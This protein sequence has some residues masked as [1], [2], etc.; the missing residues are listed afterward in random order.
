MGD[1][2]ADFKD[3]T[4]ASRISVEMKQNGSSSDDRMIDALRCISNEYADEGDPE[5][6]GLGM[7]MVSDCQHR[8]ERDH[9]RRQCKIDI[10]P[11]HHLVLHFI[12]IEID[13]TIY[14]NVFCARC[15]HAN[16][17]RGR[18][19]TLKL[20]VPTVHDA[21]AKL[22]IDMEMH[23]KV[24]L[25]QVK[26]ACSGNGF[27]VP[28]ARSLTRGRS[29]MGMMCL[30]PSTGIPRETDALVK[31]AITES[32]K[33]EIDI[34]PL[35]VDEED[36]CA[37][38]IQKSLSGPL[39]MDN[40]EDHPIFY[41]KIKSGFKIVNDVGE[42]C[43]KCDALMRSLFTPNTD[44][45]MSYF[46]DFSRDFGLNDGRMKVLFD[47]ASLI[48]CH[49]LDD[50][51]LSV[52][53]PSTVHVAVSQTGTLVS[54]ALLIILLRV[55][56]AKQ[57]DKNS[58][59]SAPGRVQVCLII[60]KIIFFSCFFLSFILRRVVCKLMSALLHSSL[61]LSFSYSMMMGIRISIMMWRLKNDFASLAHANKCKKVSWGE[62]VA[63]G[64]AVL[65]SIG[66]GAVVLIYESVTE[67]SIFGFG[68]NEFCVVTTGKGALLLVVIPTITTLIVN[69]LSVVYS[70]CVL[71]SLTNAN[72]GSNIHS[73]TVARMLTFLG[74]MISF[75]SLQWTFGLVYYVT[76]NEIVG[77]LFEIF[78]SFEGLLISSG[79]FISELRSK[80]QA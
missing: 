38:A 57:R 66:V 34:H 23:S 20:G 53:I 43:Q 11:S 58:S 31:A 1:C 50:C 62:V 9:L 63:N 33:D 48:D 60:S 2:C 24:F 6:H 15:Y 54:I 69:I 78:V 51:E 39:R 13:S 45:I 10:Q 40:H 52:A 37:R 74:R 77:F 46:Y 19:W 32:S 44:A 21:C 65:M 73:N 27:V 36:A 14:R 12:P 30:V 70:G 18:F 49:V 59:S 68:K 25:D 35:N 75:Q 16:V 47:A 55:V 76:L 26:W 56:V 8:H 3:S 64:A 61:L 71:Y 22:V 29:R 67:A 41:A 7:Y 17:R 79:F 28:N 4:I 72:G 80:Y 5:K 42:I